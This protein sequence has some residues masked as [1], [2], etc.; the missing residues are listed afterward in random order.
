MHLAP[1]RKINNILE[2]FASLLSQKI[3]PL[4]PWRKQTQPTATKSKQLS[5][6]NENGV[7]F[8]VIAQSQSGSTSEA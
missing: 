5:K 2:K 1:A 4:V 3:N 7:A 8:Q 6:E